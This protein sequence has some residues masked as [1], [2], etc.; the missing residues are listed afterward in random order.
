MKQVWKWKVPV[1]S[2]FTLE[3]PGFPEFL[4]CQ[5]QKGM[6]VFWA[7][8]EPDARLRE[9]KFRVIGT[10]VPFRSPD[11]WHYIGTFQ[12]GSQVW[13]LFVDEGK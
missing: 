10:G 9:Y 13:H 7:V 4:T 3:L 2:T 6:P 5:T 11:P 8:V 12:L 1:L